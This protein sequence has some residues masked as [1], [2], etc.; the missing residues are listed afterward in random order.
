[1]YALN[2]NVTYFDS[3]EVEHIPK[4]IKKFIDKSTVVT[5]VFRIQAYDSIMCEYFCIGFIDFMLKGKNLTDICNFFFT[6]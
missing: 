4:E 5:H 2:N 1:M 3:F 6:K